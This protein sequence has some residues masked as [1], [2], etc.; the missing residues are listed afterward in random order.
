MKGRD[1]RGNGTDTSAA[2]GSGPAAGGGAGDAGSNTSKGGIEGPEEENKQTGTED[3]QSGAKGDD[4]SS[5]TSKKI[6]CPSN[7]SLDPNTGECIPG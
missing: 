1:I 3:Q 7:K 6:E 5:D 4:V 2:A